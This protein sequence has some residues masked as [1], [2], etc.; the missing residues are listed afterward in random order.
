MVSLNKWVYAFWLALTAVLFLLIINHQTQTKKLDDLLYE[1]AVTQK[2]YFGH[3]DPE[4]LSGDITKISCVE[5]PAEPQSLVCPTPVSLTDDTNGFL[6]KTDY[7]IY[8]NLNGGG[9]RPDVFAK[10]KNAEECETRLNTSEATK[11]T[12]I[13]IQGFSDKIGSP[14]RNMELIEQRA[15]TAYDIVEELPSMKS[16]DIEIIDDDFVKQCDV[17]CFCPGA[18][19]NSTDEQNPS[20]RRVEISIFR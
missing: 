11:I 4:K 10:L 9:I 20:C 17:G 16:A 8:F 14:K 13:E 12:R 18:D 6:L 19:G 2:K 1:Y 7:T 3:S 5:C 15:K